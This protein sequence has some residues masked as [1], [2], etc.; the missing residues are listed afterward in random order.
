[1][2]VRPGRI[3]PLGQLSKEGHEGVD[4]A[5]ICEEALV[6]TQIELRDVGPGVGVRRGMYLE[7]PQKPG[8]VERREAISETNVRAGCDEILKASLVWERKTAR[9]VALR[10]RATSRT[11]RQRAF[12]SPR[13][14]VATRRAPRGSRRVERRRKTVCS[15][16]RMRS[17]AGSDHSGHRGVWPIAA[18]MRNSD[19]GSELRP[20]SGAIACPQAEPL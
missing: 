18:E 11:A 1:M 12:R 20:P 2:C 10:G 13:P 5:G 3:G 6:Q 7:R 19:D 16:I 15:R 9:C 8:T 14:S 4:R 17:C